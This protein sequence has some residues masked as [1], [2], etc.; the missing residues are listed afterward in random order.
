MPELKDIQEE[1][2]KALHDFRQYVDKELKEIKEKGSADPQTTEAIAKLNSRIDELQTKLQ[3]PQH[4]NTK[5]AGTDK[6]FNDF[7]RRGLVGEGAIAR[8]KSMSVGSDADGGFWVSPDTSGRII[9]KIFDTTPMRQIAQVISISTDKIQGMTDRDEVG[10]GWVGET[11]A[12]AETATATIGQWEIPV[13]E[14]YAEP[15]VTQKLLDDAAVDPGAFIEGKIADKFGREEN[16]AF[17]SG[18]GIMQPKGFA[19]YGTAATADATRAWG[20]IEHV[21]TG[22]AG[23]WTAANADRLYDLEFALNPRYRVNASFLAHKTAILK[24]RKFKD[25]NGNFLWQPGLQPGM[26]QTLIGYPLREAADLPAVAAN[27]LSLWFGDWK[28]AYL[29]VDRIGIRV[30]RDPYTAKPYVKFYATKRVGGAVVNFDALKA[31][32]FAAT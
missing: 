11:T 25:G 8:A 32:R 9:K 10:S 30:L 21:P 22:S 4:D 29:I 24:L 12:P 14:Q 15:R 2:Q 16:T 1:L 31:L 18:N 7:L 28:E 27:S 23:D 3:R 5:P 26:P 6:E 17:V 13:H 19:A 20:T